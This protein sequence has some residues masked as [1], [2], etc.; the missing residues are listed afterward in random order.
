MIPESKNLVYEG[1]KYKT[2][3]INRYANMGKWLFVHSFPGKAEDL[4]LTIK[5]NLRTKFCGERGGMM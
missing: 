2:D 1:G 4:V 3:L 5:N